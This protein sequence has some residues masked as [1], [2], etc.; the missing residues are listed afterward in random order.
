MMVVLSAIA[1]VVHFPVI[2]VFSFQAT[3]PDVKPQPLVIE[4][5]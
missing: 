4:Y 1:G 3:V 5:P 2:A